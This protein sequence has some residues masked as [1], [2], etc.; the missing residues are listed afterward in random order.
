MV[1]STDGQALRDLSYKYLWM[2]NRDWL[3]MAEEGDPLI[4][5]EGKGI[6]VTDSEGKSW[7]DVS[8]GYFSVNV[9]YG[10]TEIAE[11]AYQQLL[12]ANY[13][14]VRTTTPPTIMLAE[15]LAELAPGSLNRSFPVSGGSE[16]NEV[17]IKMVRAYHKRR[18]DAGPLQDN[19]SKRLLSRHDGR[20]P[21][22]WW[23]FWRGS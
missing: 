21:M 23:N 7:I 2:H 10:R 22:A 3:Q 12:K 17:A 8:A 1:T 6:R 9:G 15:K 16:A 19:Q 13:F 18:G 20:G 14:P 5:V 4:I 11:A